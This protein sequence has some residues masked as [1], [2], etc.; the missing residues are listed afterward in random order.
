[1]AYIKDKQRD[2][3][4]AELKNLKND[5]HRIVTEKAIEW[6]EGKAWDMDIA[7]WS[8]EGNSNVTIACCIAEIVEDGIRDGT[9]TLTELS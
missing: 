2:E 7:E 5:F 4:V 9:Y 6:V 1:M 8:D 3:V